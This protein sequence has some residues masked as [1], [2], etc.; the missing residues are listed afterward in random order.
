MG[1]KTTWATIKDEPVSEK[2]FLVEVEPAQHL[3]SWSLTSG[4][5][6]TY[7][8]EFLTEQSE[9]GKELLTFGSMYLSFSPGNRIYFPKYN[10]VRKIV[11]RVEENGTALDE[12]SSV[13]TV[14]AGT[15]SWWHDRANGKIYVHSSGD[16]TVNDYT[17]IV[18]FWIYFGTKGV[19]LGDYIDFDA[20][21]GSF[22]VGNTITGATSGATATIVSVYNDGVTGRLGLSDITGTF[23]DNEVIYESL[24]SELVTNSDMELDANWNDYVVPA[25]NERSGEQKHGGTY[26]RKIVTADSETEGVE[27]DTFSITADSFYYH[28]LWGYHAT[29]TDPILTILSGD[30]ATADIDIA[31]PLDSA[32]W[33]E[34]SGCYQAAVTGAGGKIRVHSGG[35]D[36][37]WYFDDF[38]IKQ[39][40]NAALAD[41]AVKS[42]YRY[43][44]PYIGERGIPSISQSTNNIFYGVT[45][46]GSGNISLINNDGYFD[47]IFKLWIW[48]NKQV[49]ILV[50]GDDLPYSEYQAIY[51][52]VISN[53]TYT[54]RDVKLQIKST[55]SGLFKTLPTGFFLTS[56]Y[57]DL[58]PSAEGKPKPIYYGV[59]SES[60]A[61]LVTCIDTAYGVNIYQFEICDHAILAISQVYVDFDDGVGWQNQAH[62]NEDLPN[63]KFTIEHADYVVGTSKVKVA[64][65]GVYSGSTAIDGAPEIAEDL[66][67][68]ATWGDY[69]GT[70]L[71]AAS[72]TASE[73]TSDVSLNVPIEK[74]TTVLKVIEKICASDFAFFDT[75]GDGLFRYR[76]WE[77]VIAGTEPLI[78]ELD[79][80]DDPPTVVEGTSD[81]YGK[82]RVGYSYS[83]STKSYLYKEEE[84]DTTLYKYG[85]NEALIHDT[86]LRTSGDATIAAQRFLFVMEDPS[87][88]LD[89]TL[90]I[91]HMDKLVGDKFKINM[92]RAPFQTAGGYSERLFEIVKTAKSA[93]P[94]RNKIT[95]R[96]I[97][98]YG[99]NVGFWQAPTAN[100]WDDATSEE[101]E[102]FGFWCDTNGYAD[103]GGIEGLNISRWW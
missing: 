52:G 70:D 61:P 11:S 73:T 66:L 40:L 60:Q 7:E 34:F 30:G 94:V 22:T 92:F 87:P 18:Y 89:I 45:S 54:R 19:I 63:A 96:D 23:Q 93:Y 48:N 77:P 99:S 86:Y 68:N 97:V 20:Q 32:S 38:S 9:I 55:A 91:Q 33:T 101:Q 21:T 2:I 31:F 100:A 24:G 59:Y 51:T 53:K 27:S 50:G 71:N 14:E 103:P 56:D 1:S 102:E 35:V 88:M 16:D 6:F 74:P 46:V 13:A 57:A 58:E 85:R 62:A 29:G 28:S 10:T 95:A 78:D 47:K 17:I 5:T 26:S 72:F 4:E 64:F 37:T 65:T 36:S 39:L 25:T 76:T 79:Y 83:C 75:D 12:K 42:S 3:E 49:R 90:K 43:Y 67:T 82:V 80:L 44:E 69:A 98:N 81:V 84:S 41:G 8:K 15:G